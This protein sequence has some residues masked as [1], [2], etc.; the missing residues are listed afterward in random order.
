MAALQ[1]SERLHGLPVGLIHPNKR[2]LVGGY[3]RRRRADDMGG[4][5]RRRWITNM[6]QS[7]EI[8][9]I[10]R[11][12]SSGSITAITHPPPIGFFIYVTA[13][14][15]QWGGGGLATCLSPTKGAPS[16]Q[17]HITDCSRQLKETPG[18]AR[19]AVWGVWPPPGSARSRWVSR[20][21]VLA[22]ADLPALALGN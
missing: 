10:S 14:Y 16:Q 4:G 12:A 13:T 15:G 5:E 17:L 18:V 22:M 6:M 1:Q 9:S 7:E 19:P 8:R 11:R 3:E 20:L 2:R 21:P